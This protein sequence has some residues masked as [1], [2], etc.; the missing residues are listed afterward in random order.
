MK[1]LPT[2]HQSL[3][4]KFKRCVDNKSIEKMDKKLYHFFM[5][6]CGFIAH[7]N[8]QGFRGTYEGKDFTSWFENFANSNWMFFLGDDEYLLLKEECVKYAKQQASYVYEHFEREEH[9]RKIL[10][11][12]ELANELGKTNESNQIKQVVPTSLFQEEETGQLVLFA[13]HKRRK[14]K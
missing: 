11:F 3:F 9:N 4:K 8:L 1:G 7:Y 12:H 14:L 6:H 13:C 5:H 10:L 2:D